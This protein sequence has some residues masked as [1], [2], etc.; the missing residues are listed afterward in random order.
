MR[1]LGLGWTQYA[2]RWSSNKDSRLGTVAHLTELLEEIVVEEKTRE[3]FTP[4]SDRGLPTEAAPPQGEWRDSAQL[5]TLDADAQQA[6]QQTRFSREQLESKAQA[7]MQRRVE[8]GIADGVELRQPEH[9][10]AFDQRLVGKRIEVL[11][12]YWE[13]EADGSRVP[14]YIWCTGRVVR[15]A[16]GLTDQRSAKARSILPGGAVLW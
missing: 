11:W 2:T 8:A 5:G 12:R 4:G 9:A 15:I 16:D 6:R 7:E 13:T 1:V 3:R 10:P 14:H